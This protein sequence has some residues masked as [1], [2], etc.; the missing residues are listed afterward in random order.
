MVSIFHLNL[1]FVLIKQGTMA[2]EW[3]DIKGI[4]AVNYEKEPQCQHR[5]SRELVA[6][7][8]SPPKKLPKGKGVGGFDV[9]H[10]GML[11]GGEWEMRKWQKGKE[12]GGWKWMR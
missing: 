7:I 12:C 1:E 9:T 4:C 2:S 5:E 8:Q 6:A 11:G 10:F 3:Q